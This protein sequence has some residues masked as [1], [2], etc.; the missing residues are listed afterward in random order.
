MTT[1]PSAPAQAQRS[2]LDPDPLPRRDFLGMAAA[3][4]AAGAMLFALFG[5]MAAFA[6]RDSASTAAGERVAMVGS[7]LA[8]RYKSAYRSAVVG[9][10]MHY[11]IELPRF[12][13]ISSGNVSGMTEEEWRSFTVHSSSANTLAH[14]LVHAYVRLATPASDPLYAMATEGIHFNCM[15]PKDI[16][17]RFRKHCMDLGVSMRQRVLQLVEADC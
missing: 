12:G 3:W 17:V 8:R 14:E 11:L 1:Q 4:S 7:E 2:R 10:G 5:A 16:H 15:L 9:G 6:L 13:Q